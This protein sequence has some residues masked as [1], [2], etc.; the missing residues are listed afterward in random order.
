[1]ESKNHVLE[2]ILMP[3]SN[4]STVSTNSEGQSLLANKNVNSRGKINRFQICPHTFITFSPSV[5]NM[6]ELARDVGG[7][8][9]KRAGVQSYLLIKVSLPRK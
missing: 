3:E 6:G 2:I 5:Q 8:H 9:N 1:M 4:K 7:K